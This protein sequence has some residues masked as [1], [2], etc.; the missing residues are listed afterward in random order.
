MYQ[1]ITFNEGKE[2]NNLIQRIVDNLFLI[3]I[4]STIDIEIKAFQSS[5]K[6]FAD[7]QKYKCFCD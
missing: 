4:L 6:K 7:S 2:M 5:T 1:H 3:K